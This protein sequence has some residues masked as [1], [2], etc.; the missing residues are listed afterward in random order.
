MENGLRPFWAHGTTSQAGIG[1]I[2]KE[3][4]L[5]KFNPV[6][7]TSWE[8]IETGRAAVLRLRGPSGALDIFVI[9]LATGDSGGKMQRAETLRKV[10]AA[11]RPRE[12]VLSLI[13]GDFNFVASARDRF[14]KQQA[15]WTGQCDE[16][17]QELFSTLIEK[18][19]DMYELEQEHCT[20]ENAFARSRLDRVYTNQ[21]LSEQLDRHS[22]CAVLDWVSGLSAHRP[23][24]FSR[25]RAG[26][27]P[28]HKPLPTAPMD[29]PRWSMRVALRF[30]ELRA[31][32]TNIDQALRRLLLLKKAIEGVTVTMHR[33]GCASAAATPDDKL[34]WT[35][36]FIRAAE[37]I[38]VRTMERCI[39]SY[40]HL[41]TLVEGLSPNLRIGSGL[42]KVRMHALELARSAVTD[43]LRDLESGRGTMDA[44][45][46]MR[47][48]ENIL[49]RLKRLI[50]GSA[51]CLKAMCNSRG[52]VTTEPSKMADLLREHW[53]D[54]FKRTDIDSDTLQNWLTSVF[55][56]G[57]DGRT[58]SGL[59]HA[60]Q[61]NG[62]CARRTSK[63]R[64]STPLTV[65]L[66]QTGFLTWH[67]ASSAGWRR[68]Y[69]SR[70]R[71]VY[72]VQMG[73]ACS[74]KRRADNW[75]ASMTSTF[76]FFAAFLKKRLAMMP[77]MGTISQEK[78][79]DHCV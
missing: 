71:R 57:G 21:H 40:P 44:N 41:L 6:T 16:D 5:N 48:K 63:S 64:S 15:T 66:V 3:E 7:D 51:T 8:Y 26:L 9:Y 78:R 58:V 77:N 17:E 10:A 14:N 24:S 45:Q 67:G 59:P 38:R 43:E 33:E 75:T 13:V 19:H 11:M 2:I 73:A 68:R 56:D 52:E 74:D 1:L 47:R 55:P 22:S 69:Y 20:H 27:P 35:V 61:Q 30:E 34:G 46:L 28:S 36:R 18:E 39:D 54:V 23:I 32:D 70:Q 60:T 50:P 29:D 25:R 42:A 53:S 31:E 72:R 79:L 4:F 76:Q 49:V 12:E 62:D 37:E 65:H